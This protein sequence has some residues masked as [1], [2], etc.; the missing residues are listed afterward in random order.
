MFTFA[1]EEPPAVLS[2]SWFAVALTSVD[3][4]A[5]SDVRKEQEGDDGAHGS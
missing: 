5:T 3:I 4:I 1:K 2:L